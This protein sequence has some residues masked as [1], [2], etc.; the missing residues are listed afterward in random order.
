VTVVVPGSTTSA[1]PT[2]S[3]SP[4][5]TKAQV[6]KTPKGGVDTGEAPEPGAGSYG[7]IA[8][9]SLMLAGSVTGGLLLRRRRAEHAGGTNR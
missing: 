9:G 8:G 4:T 1:T 3:A 6:V 5:A 2:A 7:L